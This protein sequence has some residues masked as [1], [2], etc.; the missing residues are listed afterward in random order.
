[1]EVSVIKPC[2]NAALVSKGDMLVFL[3]MISDH[4]QSTRIRM[5]NVRPASKLGKYVT[6]AGRDVV[7]V[8]N[9]CMRVNT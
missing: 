5:S 3:R 4:S 1:M 6:R 7:F 9:E 2:L 8:R